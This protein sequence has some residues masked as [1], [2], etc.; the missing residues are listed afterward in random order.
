LIFLDINGFKAINDTHGHEAGDQVLR[1]LGA[2]LKR[3]VREN[4]LGIRWGGEEVLLVFLTATG[5]K[6]FMAALQR[7]LA[8]IHDADVQKDYGYRLN[9]LLTI[10]A[11]G[12]WLDWDTTLNRRPLATGI[13][14][15]LVHQADQLMY[16]SKAA[17][18]ENNGALRFPIERDLL[19]NG[20]LKTTA[21][22]EVVL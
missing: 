10:A 12:V 16:K 18:K 1:A 22:T 6:Q 21:S 5:W 9:G 11:G 7:I 17:F 13:A 2:I 14:E 4:D 20:E 8:D 19:F 15:K 3:G